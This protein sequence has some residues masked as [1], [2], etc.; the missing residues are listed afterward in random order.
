[1]GQCRLEF[2]LSVMHIILPIQQYATLEILTSF[3]AYCLFNGTP[4]AFPFVV[5]ISFKAN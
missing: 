4:G 5:E 1:M 2:L 3:G